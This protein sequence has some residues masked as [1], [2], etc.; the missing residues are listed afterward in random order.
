MTVYVDAIIKWPHA[1]GIFRN[2][3]CHLTADTVEELHAFAARLGMKRS[4][5]Q[6]QGRFEHYD[7]TPASRAVAVSYGAKEETTREGARRRRAA[8][9]AGSP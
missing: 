6:N 8:R 2:G 5:F 4:W 9:Q 1:R 7:L 3:S